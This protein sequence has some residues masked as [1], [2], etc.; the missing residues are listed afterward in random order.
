[1]GF[2]LMLALAV[3]IVF[4][5]VMFRLVKK[6]VPLAMHAAFGIFVFWLLKYLGVLN[7]PIDIVTLLIAAFGGVL[8]VLMVIGLSMIG[9]PL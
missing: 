5:Y 4:F 2:G 7:V 6:V 3:S 8:G 1:M 9:I